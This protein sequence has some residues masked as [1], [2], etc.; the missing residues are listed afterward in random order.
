MDST[1]VA[2]NRCTMIKPRL[3]SRESGHWLPTRPLPLPTAP[4]TAQNLPPLTEVLHGLDSRE[5]EGDTLFD[6][7]FGDP[8]SA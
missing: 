5:L 8:P 1:G 7:L 2:N 6:Q 4:E 3:A